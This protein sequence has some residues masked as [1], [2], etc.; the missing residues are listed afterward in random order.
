MLVFWQKTSWTPS[1]LIPQLTVYGL[2]KT[3]R[4]SDMAKGIESEKTKTKHFSYESTVIFALQF[5][6]S[7]ILAYYIMLSVK[8]KKTITFLGPRTLIFGTRIARWKFN[9]H[10]G[11]FIFYFLFL[12]PRGVPF[13][14]LFFYPRKTRTS[15]KR[16][17]TFKR[18]RLLLCNFNDIL[19]NVSIC[20]I[21]ECWSYY[22]TLNTTNGA[23][24]SK[25]K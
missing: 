22:Y 13:F 21:D 1:L 10:Y 9:T 2:N 18:A 8:K 12:P 17:G 3:R 20:R 16:T 19:K 7:Y 4:I 6:A 24:F 5:L 25:F 23:Y 14:F 15:T 11:I